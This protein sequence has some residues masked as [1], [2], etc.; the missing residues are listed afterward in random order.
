M[1]D[2][3]LTQDY[4]SFIKGIKDRILSSRYK[5]ARAVNQE[6]ILLY[7][8]IGTQILE[9]QKSQGWGAKVIDHLSK[10]LKSQFPEMK[11]FS[12]RN[13]K[14]MRQF[15]ELYPDSE[16]VQ[17]VAAQLP[18]FHIA[19]LITRVKDDIERQFYFK[20]AIE[21]GWSRN[22]LEMHIDTKLYLRQG[23]ATTNFKDRLPT[24]QSDLANETIKNPYSF[25]FLN[26]GAD[27][28]EREIENGLEKHIEKFLLELGEGFAYLGRQYSIIVDDEEYFLDMLFYH[29]RLRCFVVIE[30]KARKFRPS[31]TGQLNF[32][33]TAIDEQLKHK[34]DNQTIGILLC[35]SKKGVSVEYAL[36][37]LNSPIGVSE[38]RLTG[39]LPE[40]IKTA[41]PSIEQIEF[42][43]SKHTEE[44]KN[45]Q[46]QETDQQKNK[47]K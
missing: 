5:A 7:H 18:W 15:A 35:Q 27:A 10:D 3:N 6:L 46:S 45:S 30:L 8:H 32:Y 43:L 25:D 29:I 16:F 26:L 28:H 47:G 14:Y 12:S 31:D 23:S 24:S 40:N 1:S 9:K 21:N 20:K 13:L 44:S 37:N 17:Q 22:I 11:G 4:Q 34:S 38:Y 41:L 19:V 2:L 36:R 42:E 33:L 39:E